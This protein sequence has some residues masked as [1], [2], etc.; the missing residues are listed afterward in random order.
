VRHKAT[1]DDIAWHEVPALRASRLIKAIATTP[2]RAWLLNV[3]NPY[4]ETTAGAGLIAKSDCSNSAG[5]T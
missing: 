1:I 5:G 3:V 4:F 2:L